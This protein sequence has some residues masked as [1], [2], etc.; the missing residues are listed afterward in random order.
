LPTGVKVK[1]SKI[2]GIESEGMFCLDSELGVSD[3]DK[4][5][6]FNA[7]I[8]PGTPITEAMDISEGAVLD[9]ENKSITHRPDL[10]SHIG[11]AREVA[12]ILNKNL[13]MPAIKDLKE[14]SEVDLKIEIKDKEACPRY[15]GVAVSGI[16]VGPSPSW[17]QKFLLSAGMR[18]INNIVD[19]TNYVMLEMGQPL[20]A[21]D[22]RQIQDNKIIVKKALQG[23]KFITLDGDGRE[24]SKDDL[25]INDPDKAVAL[26]GVMGGENSEVQSDTK[27]IIIESANFEPV[28]LRKTSTRLNLR[29]EASARFEKGLDAN[30]AEQAAKRAV[31]LVLEI[32]PGSKVSSKFV[33]INYSK[34]KNAKVEVDLDFL[35]TRIGQEIPVR[36]VIDILESLE[37]KVKKIKNNLQVEAPS[38][39]S[40]GDVSI[41]EDIVE[42]VARIYGFNNLKVTLPA[43][44][45][46]R[47]E[48]D[49][50]KEL[51]RKIKEYMVGAGFTEVYNYSFI[52]P[53]DQKLFGFK[54]NDLIKLRNYFSIDQSIMRP[55]LVPNLIKNVELNLRF[56]SQFKI[57]E[58]ARVFDKNKPGRKI[59][60]KTNQ[61][62]PSQPKRLTGMIVERNFKDLFFQIKGVAESLAEEYNFSLSFEN[63]DHKWA[64]QG[65]SLKVKINGKEAGH[66][67]IYNHDVYPVKAEVAIFD[68]DFKSFIEQASAIKKFKKLNEYPAVNRDIAIVVSKEI[69]WQEIEKE[70]KTTDN[71]IKEVSFLSVFKDIKIGSDKKSM[72]FSITFRADDRTLESEEVDK[73]VEKILKKLAGKFQAKI[74]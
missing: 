25:L 18:P 59:S 39:R 58:L 47:P 45:M 3:D 24:L 17:I 53:E 31:N 1:K 64:K 16:K 29:T 69:T 70:I 51:E 41:P 12:A 38:F 61:Y 37:F 10:W 66:I 40:T 56:Y 4:C 14:D 63:N 46:E 35:Y 50:E 68:L 5:T 9:I 21:F 36:K 62:L 33:D 34:Q 71:L 32:I 7:D 2:R 22:I 55:S 57:F 48:V 27:T 44:E 54:D 43:I 72:A 6:F 13:K 26:A 67:Y 11:I 65:Q 42:E 49:E 8:K 28:T 19:I 74:R 52:S 30:L 20:H 23:Q 15:I 60:D 73:I